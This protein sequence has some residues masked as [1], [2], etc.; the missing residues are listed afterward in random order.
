VTVYNLKV[1]EFHT[2]YAGIV[3]V[4]VHNADYQGQNY[5]D[6]K[7]LS[8]WPENGDTGSTRDTDGG[9][10]SSSF[11]DMM[12]PEE[13][14]RYNKYWEKNAPTHS[15]PGAKFDHYKLNGNVIERSTV[16]YDEFGRQ[17]YRID[18]N[19]HGYPDH[20]KPHLHEK[21]WLPG[22]GPDSGIN[23]RYDWWR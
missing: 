3:S 22:R 4:L 21:T 11:A 13:A 19:N 9:T 6:Q 1:D 16:I 7:P 10:G 14:A 12:S 5:D 15:T 23:N 2:Y 18:Y 20:S 8:D 17:K